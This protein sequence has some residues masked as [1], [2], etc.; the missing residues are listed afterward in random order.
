MRARIE[1]HTHAHRFLM[2]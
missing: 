1:T 2:Q